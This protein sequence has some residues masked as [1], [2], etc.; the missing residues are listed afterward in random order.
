MS[1]QTENRS[2]L[3]EKRRSHRASSVI[4]QRH[5]IFLRRDGS[6]SNPCRLG[7]TLCVPLS[8]PW[9]VRRPRGARGGVGGGSA[10]LRWSFARALALRLSLVLNA[11]RASTVT[12]GPPV[13]VSAFFD[14]EVRGG[15]KIGRPEGRRWNLAC[16]SF[17]LAQRSAEPFSVGNRRHRSKW[18]RR[19][20]I[21]G[22]V[23]SARRPAA[24]EE[25]GQE[26]VAPPSSSVCPGKNKL[27]ARGSLEGG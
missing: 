27:G 1:A 15:R 10:G 17:S 25:G 2:I 6:A 24:R 13:F 12:E 4:A 11:A 18:G 14:N 8:S 19:N 7:R 26:R 9:M 20:R 21:R 22:D 16:S 5:K 23:R 3:F